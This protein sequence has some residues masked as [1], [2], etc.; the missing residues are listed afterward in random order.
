MIYS[1]N[2]YS[3]LSGAAFVKHRI[4]KEIYKTAIDLKS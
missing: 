2:A 3:I 4:Y 1:M